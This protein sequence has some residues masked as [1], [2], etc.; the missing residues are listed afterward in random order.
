MKVN[1]LNCK[2]KAKIFK[3]MKGERQKYKKAIVTLEKGKTL[4][5]GTGAK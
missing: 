2:P 1:I 4:D 3:G 5:L